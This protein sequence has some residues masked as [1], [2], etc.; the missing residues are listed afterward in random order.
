[1]ESIPETAA[2]RKM[3]KG[4]WFS[5]LAWSQEQETAYI[6]ARKRKPT[7]QL[8]YD[9]YG[10]CINLGCEHEELQLSRNYEGALKA[11]GVERWNTEQRL[12][13]W[14]IVVTEAAEKV[15]RRLDDD[16]L[17]EIREKRAVGL[18]HEESVKQSHEALKK[19]FQK[20]WR[21]P[22]ALF[23]MHM[24]WGRILPRREERQ[25]RGTLQLED[26]RQQQRAHNR[27]IRQLEDVIQHERMNVRRLEGVI[28]DREREI[29][30]L[31]QELVDARKS[32]SANRPLNSRHYY[33]HNRPVDS[34]QHHHR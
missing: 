28:H 23:T 32:G 7:E 29:Q 34:R 2:D 17:R 5:E 6:E 33:G 19:S 31:R 30:V 21:N 22:S 24:S 8:V 20:V 15:G 11:M 10:R 13:V 18:F 4:A 26:L 14:M 1:M 27:Q 3:F 16:L 12:D 9:G 25:P